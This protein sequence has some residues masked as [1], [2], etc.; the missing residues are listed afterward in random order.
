VISVAYVAL[1][2]ETVSQA[3][4]NSWPVLFYY[5]NYASV[6]HQ[7]ALPFRHTWSL[8]VEEQFYVVWPLFLGSLLILLRRNRG[9]RTFLTVCLVLI[10]VASFALRV[11]TGAAVLP[12]TTIFSMTAGA[13]LAV[14]YEHGWRPGRWA[15]T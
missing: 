3:W 9:R 7:L 11:R 1:N 6:H 4:R 12:Q 5:A 14:W 2:W 10:T 8:A 15:M 13:T